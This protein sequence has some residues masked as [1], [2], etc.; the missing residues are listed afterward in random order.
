MSLDEGGREGSTRCQRSCSQGHG[1]TLTRT[2][3]RTVASDAGF[4]VEEHFPDYLEYRAGGRG[5]R[6]SA[7][8]STAAGTSILLFY[9]AVDSRWQPPHREDPLDGVAVRTILVRVVAAM[10]FLRIRADWQTLPP[11]AERD[12]WAAIESEARALLP[13]ARSRAPVERG[14]A[15]CSN[16]RTA[17][18]TRATSMRCSRP[19]PPRSIGRTAWTEG[20]CAATPPSASTGRGNGR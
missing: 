12:D 5:F 6:I 18:S 14:I 20:V 11:D 3:P 9:D 1:V 8:M 17:P 7:E 10:L 4:E 13:R 19:C 16:V 2:G 15:S